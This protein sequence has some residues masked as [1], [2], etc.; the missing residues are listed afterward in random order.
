[1]LKI[2]IIGYFA[3]E[4]VKGLTILI[5]YMVKGGKQK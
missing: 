4:T 2:L 1:M 3:I 5:K